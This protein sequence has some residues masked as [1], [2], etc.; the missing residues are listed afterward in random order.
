MGATVLIVLEAFL[1][2]YT[3]LWN[4]FLGLFLMAAAA[5]SLRQRRVGHARA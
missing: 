1:S 5:L 3:D 4:L 2:A